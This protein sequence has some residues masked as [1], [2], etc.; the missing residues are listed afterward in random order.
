MGGTF[1]QKYAD[2]YSVLI[3]SDAAEDY[4]ANEGRILE[5]YAAIDRWKDWALVGMGFA[6]NYRQALYFS[7]KR[8]QSA[9]YRDDGTGAHDI[10]VYFAT[11]F[12]TMGLI[13]MLLIHVITVRA[14]LVAVK[15]RGE[16]RV[17]GQCLAVGTAALLIGSWAGN[18]FA[19]PYGA[20]VAMSAIG[21]LCVYQRLVLL[22]SKRQQARFTARRTRQVTI[23]ADIVS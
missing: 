8:A 10:F 17:E 21:M 2:R 5:A 22:P 3:N 1:A 6:P 19:S 16:Y 15:D 12:G 9:I 23:V 14:L 4:S 11:R 18:I 20:P 13:S 7:T